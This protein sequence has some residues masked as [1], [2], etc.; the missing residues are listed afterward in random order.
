VSHV[1][2]LVSHVLCFVF[3]VS[4][5]VFCVSC[6][7]FCVLCSVSHISC[8][9]FRVSWFVFRVSGCGDGPLA[10]RL[11]ESV[12]G[13]NLLLRLREDAVPCSEFKHQD[14]EFERF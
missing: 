5:F 8:F 13:C 10:A 3:G 11:G 6:L 9:V 14:L 4:C 7:M 12:H 1:S 2:C